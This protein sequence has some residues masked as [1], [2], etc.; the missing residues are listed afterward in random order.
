MEIGVF[1]IPLDHATRMSLVFCVYYTDEGTGPDCE[2]WLNACEVFLYA[3]L[4]L[5][6]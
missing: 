6:R 4:T 5:L 2:L 3:Y 1:L